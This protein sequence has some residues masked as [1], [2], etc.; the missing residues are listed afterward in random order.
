MSELLPIGPSRVSPTSYK[1]II[2]KVRDLYRKT[3]PYGCSQNI[4]AEVRDID[5]A[6]EANRLREKRVDEYA[7]NE[8]K[9]L[10]LSKDKSRLG[11]SFTIHAKSPK[12]SKKKMR[13]SVS[14]PKTADF[15]IRRRF[16]ESATNDPRAASAAFAVRKRRE[17]RGN[18]LK[19]NRIASLDAIMK[20]CDELKPT[21]KPDLELIQN[22]E[23]E[24]VSSSNNVKEFIVDMEDCMKLAD[25]EKKMN[26]LMNECKNSR[27]F[28]KFMSVEPGIKDEMLTVTRRLVQFGGYKVWRHN[29]AEFMASAEK[30]INSIPKVRS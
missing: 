20:S 5:K 11:K 13:F 21:L 16:S 23:A 9:K 7:Q 1:D 17:W 8:L 4:K 22:H 18:P 2:T 12:D 28:N 19:S 10:N 25:N 30:I 27:K 29:H 14:K 24:F 15:K 6:V 26:K 3:S